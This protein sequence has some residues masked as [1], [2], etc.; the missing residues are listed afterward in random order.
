[1]NYLPV[2]RIHMNSG[3]GV[4]PRPRTDLNGSGLPTRVSTD[5]LIEPCA[6][7]SGHP[8]WVTAELTATPPDAGPTRH[9]VA[10]SGSRLTAQRPV[11]AQY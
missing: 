6:Q 7:E 3:T 4:R 1:M 11:P 2:R 9:A 8:R 10:T 5:Q